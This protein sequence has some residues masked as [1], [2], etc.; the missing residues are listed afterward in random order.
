MIKGPFSVIATNAATRAV[1]H[2]GES[3]WL[4]RPVPRTA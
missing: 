4:S 3:A 2:G 1:A